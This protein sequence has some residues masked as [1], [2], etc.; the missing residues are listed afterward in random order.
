MHLFLRVLTLCAVLLPSPARATVL[1]AA[2]GEDI[3]VTTDTDTVTAVTTAG[4]LNAGYTRQAVGPTQQNAGNHF[5][6]PTVAWTAAAT[7]FWTRFYWSHSCASTLTIWSGA[8]DYDWVRWYDASGVLRLSLRLNDSE[9]VLL[10]KHDATPTAT[11]LATSSN[12]ITSQSFL[13]V[14]IDYQASG[15]FAVYNGG[16]LIHSYSG[17]VTTNSVT[18]LKEV[19]FGQALHSAAGATA[20]YN[21][22]IV[23]TT[24]SRGMRVVSLPPQADGNA[25]QWTGAYSDID[26]TTLSDADFIT[27]DADSQKA[28]VTIGAL[29][30]GTWSV[31]AIVQVARMNRGATGPQQIQWTARVSGT[32]YNS[33]SVGLNLA[34]TTQGFI[35]ATNPATSAAWTAAELGTAGLNFGLE[36]KN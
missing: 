9:Q 1:W 6:K 36:S 20:R 35:R 16:T 25:M 26:E 3:D 11:L 24:D 27:T 12:S 14:Y 33:G 5:I 19:R 34:L 32:D 29:P 17:D 21:E 13:D 23:S 4:C 22:M 2:A 8:T 31:P 7:T 15:T 18:A 28:Q 10:Y 30:A